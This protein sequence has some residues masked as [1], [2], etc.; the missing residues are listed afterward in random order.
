ML[1]FTFH[2]A[3]KFVNNDESQSYQT[4]SPQTSLDNFTWFLI[5]IIDNV[6]KIF[7]FVSSYTSECQIAYYFR[8]II[9]TQ[10]ILC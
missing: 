10:K 1:N 6:G 5:P 9:V 3:F 2:T 7:L 8:Q 4:F